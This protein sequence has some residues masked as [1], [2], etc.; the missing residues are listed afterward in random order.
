VAQIKTKFIENSAVTAAKIASDAVTTAKIADSNVTNDKVASG[1]D[2]AKLADGSV[3]NTEF[4]Y[5]GGVTS[6]VQVQLDAKVDESRE[7]VANG[8]ATLDAGGKIPAS[9]LPS[10]VM[11]YK[12]TWAAST[13]T[14]TLANGTGDAGDVYIA[15]DAGSVNFGAGA[16]SFAAGDWVIYNGTIWQKSANSDSVVSVNGFTGVVVLDTDD[17][18]E[19]TALYFTN[20]RAQDAVGTILTDTASVDLTYDDAGNQISADVLPAGVNHNALQNYVANEHVDHSAVSVTTNANS[21]L[22]GGG[23]ITA[24]RSLVIDPTNAPSV[25][26][27][28]GDQ[29]LIADASDSNNLKRVTVDSIAALAAGTTGRKVDFNLVAG[30]ITN[31]YVDFLFVALNNTVQISVDG[32]IQTEGTDYTLNYTGGVSGSTR[33]T[34]AGDLATGGPAALVSG[35]IINLQCESAT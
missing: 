18:A 28:T 10:S 23:N 35:D 25:S 33:L 21:G 30:D 29:L 1:I 7:G 32:V 4:Q 3:S 24:S 11:E 12:G 22:T 14:P 17:I 6:D 5:L 16:I 9:Q 15:S 8:I 2:A 26:A 27:A 20:E 31:Q 34:F 19:G 13:N